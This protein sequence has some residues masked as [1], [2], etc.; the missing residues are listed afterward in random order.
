MPGKLA[1][2]LFPYG[3]CLDPC[4]EGGDIDLDYLIHP[5]KIDYYTPFYRR[6][7]SI[8][9]G[10]LA[11]RRKRDPV[12][13]CPF[14]KRPQL[15]F[16]IRLNNGIGKEIAGER[17]H[18]TGQDRDVMAVQRALSPVERDAAAEHLIE[19]RVSF[20]VKFAHCAPLYDI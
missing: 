1:V 5:V 15:F 12:N 14:D 17:P 19:I 11:A 13:T 7:P 20:H 9:G 10:S 2:K 18:K 3:A 4:G 6:H 8:T 16:G